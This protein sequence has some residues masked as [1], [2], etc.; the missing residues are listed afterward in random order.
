MMPI[1]RM[2]A[3][4]LLLTLGGCQY[5]TIQSTQLSA[6]LSVFLPDSNAWSDSLWA[7]EYGGYSTSVQ[8]VTVDSSTVFVND[9]D[10]VSFDGW[11]ITKVSGLNSFSPAWIIQD[12]GEQRSFIVNGQVVTTHQCAPW[13]KRGDELG[14]RFEQQC[15]GKK[16]YTNT[17]L[18]D[19]QGQIINIEQVVDSSLMVLRLSFNN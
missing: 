7:I 3:I 2:I 5:V 16:A 19:N 14:V 4:G 1:L 8:P 10:S 12:S 11:H 6:L 17:I 9:T 18:V 13:L 15:V